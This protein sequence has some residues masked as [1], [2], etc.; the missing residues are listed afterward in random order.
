M[1]D[2][3]LGGLRLTQDAGDHRDDRSVVTVELPTGSPDRDRGEQRQ[4]A[5]EAATDGVPE[6]PVET[7][8]ERILRERRE[9]IASADDVE[10]FEGGFSTTAYRRAAAVFDEDDDRLQL[11]EHYNFRSRVFDAHGRF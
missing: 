10:I 1:A 4:F 7:E 8:D 5:G 6:V 9:F 11:A 2:K 3:N